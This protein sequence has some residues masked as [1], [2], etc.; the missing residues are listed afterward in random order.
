M[1]CK[2]GCGQECNKTYISG[3]NHR[4]KKRYWRVVS[5]VSNIKRS[6]TLKGRKRMPFS[7]EW[8]ENIGKS[9]RGIKKGPQTVEHRRNVSIS[10]K[11]KYTGVKS[12]RYGKPPAHRKGKRFY[13]EV[14]NQ[15][16][17]YLRSSYEVIFATYLLAKQVDFRYEYKR[18]ILDA[19]TFLPDFYLVKE[20]KFI[21]V[22][23]YVD[24]VSL[25]KMKEMSIFHPD[26]KIE[27]IT[28]KEIKEIKNGGIL[29]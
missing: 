23:G 29:C 9:Q 4:G 15:G 18:F 16:I 28:S 14:P 13:F 6:I 20:D 17:V 24:T 26:I 22:K 8:K 25:Q 12:I 11:G 2:C 3:H 5:D 1:L 7:K 27:M 21:E 19:K 10:L